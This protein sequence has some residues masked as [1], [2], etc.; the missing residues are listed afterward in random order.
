MKCY[1]ITYTTLRPKRCVLLGCDTYWV[2]TE[3]SPR[4]KA[5]TEVS[6]SIPGEA[7][8]C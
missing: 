5:V 7:G 4:C 2:V 6:V 1:S 3:D 8:H